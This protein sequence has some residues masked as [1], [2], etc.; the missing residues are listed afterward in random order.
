MKTE[1]KLGKTLKELM[2]TEP[3][4]TITV[5]RL[6]TLCG[7]NRQTFYYH[8][9][10]IYDLLTWIFLNESVHGVDQCKS[11]QEVF[12]KFLDYVDTNIIFIQNTLNSAGRE[13]FKDF[14]FNGIYA[15]LLRLLAYT[16]I[17]NRLSIEDRKFVSKF[18]TAALVHSLISWIDTGMKENREV[19]V[20]RISILMEDY[21]EN[22]I[23][24]FSKSRG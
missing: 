13:L 11:W 24:K 5:K 1:D 2:V 19:F 7:I 4:D 12:N 16:D 20:R 17:D 18:Y 9:R 14:M 22:T 21:I 10:D 15:K 23:S 3:L 6:S 8:F